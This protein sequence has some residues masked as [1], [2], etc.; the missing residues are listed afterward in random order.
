MKSCVKGVIFSNNLVSLFC[1][2]NRYIVNESL[3]KFAAF[4]LISIEIEL[5]FVELEFSF[6]VYNDHSIFISDSYRR[7]ASFI[8]LI[9][10]PLPYS[11]ER[12]DT[13]SH[14]ERAKKELQHILKVR[15]TNIL[16][17]NTLVY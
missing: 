3:H 4:E 8:Y 7:K 16:Y 14:V 15:H 13:L 6:T 1:N 5:I 11:T 2:L 12:E 10:S 17:T 9:Y